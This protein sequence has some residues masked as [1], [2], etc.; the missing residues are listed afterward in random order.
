MY[1]DVHNVKE[2]NNGGEP[3]ETEKG[4]GEEQGEEEDEQG[5]ESEEEMEEFGIT[6]TDGVRKSVSRRKNGQ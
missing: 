3:E 5:E 6:E 1:I 4:E 2:T